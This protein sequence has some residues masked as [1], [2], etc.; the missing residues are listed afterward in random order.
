MALCTVMYTCTRI[1]PHTRT[2]EA[3]HPQIQ[4]RTPLHMKPHA[5]TYEATHP[6]THTHTHRHTASANHG[7]TAL[8]DAAE[9]GFTETCMVL[10]MHGAPLHALVSHKRTHIK[11]HI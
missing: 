11:A 7:A 5:L 3:T 10:L 4:R 6:K 1:K 9:R 2:Y 8:H